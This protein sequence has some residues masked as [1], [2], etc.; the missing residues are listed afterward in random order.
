MQR[1]S[2]YRIMW[3]IVFFDLPTETKKE[4][5]IYAD[6]RKRLLKGGFSMFQF[7]IYVRHCASYENAIV[8]ATR[9]KT[10]LPEKG[11]VVIMKITDKQFGEMEIYYGRK[12]MPPADTGTQLELF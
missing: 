8:H 12:T 9:V 4:R 5:K 2:E 1:F 11:H 7:S 6:F 10:H 3:V